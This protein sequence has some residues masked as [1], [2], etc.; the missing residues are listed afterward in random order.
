MTY[1]T[2]IKDYK[3]AYDKGKNIT[4]LLREKEGRDSNTS[5]IIE[6][7]YDIQAGSYIQGYE[8]SKEYTN[9]YVQQQLFFIEKYVKNY[10]SILDLGCGELTCLFPLIQAINSKPDVFAFDI[11]WSRLSTGLDHFNKRS[12]SESYNSLNVFCSDMSHIPLPSNSIDVVISSHALEP[13]HGRER[14]LIK[15]I[16]RVAKEYVILFEP[17]FEQASDASK[18]RMIKHGYVRNLP[19]IAEELGAKVIEQTLVSVVSNPLNPTAA[20]VLK[21]EKSALEKMPEYVDPIGLNSMTLRNNYYYSSCA[22]VS[23]PI[24]ENIPILRANNAILTTALR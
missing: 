12:T 4:E 20:L 14:E 3:V 15:E 13:N 2:K 21:K 9:K 23:F 6:T 10:N 18:K 1:I 24:I 5:Q 22:G 8:E 19:S 11:S 16:M 7:A 17:C